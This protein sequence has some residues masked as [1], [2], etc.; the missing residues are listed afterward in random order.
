MQQC[1]LDALFLLSVEWL[2]SFLISEGLLEGIDDLIFRVK[3]E[4]LQD[5]IS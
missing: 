1:L 4:E 3:E 5:C 2:S